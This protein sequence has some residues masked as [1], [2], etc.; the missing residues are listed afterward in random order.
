[1]QGR[2]S[3][4]ME[5]QMLMNGGI[6][7]FSREFMEM[8]SINTH[9]EEFKRTISLPLLLTRKPKIFRVSSSF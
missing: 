9:Y 6:I 2:F 4:L 3:F 8:E 7:V 5:I 1:M